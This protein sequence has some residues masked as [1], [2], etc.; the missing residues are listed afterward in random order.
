M[1]YVTLN[2]G[3][4]PP[5]PASGKSAFFVGSD[6]RP[7]MVSDH[8]IQTSLDTLDGLNFLRN[9]GFWFAQRQVPGTLTTYSSTAGRAFTADGWA[10]TNENAS[11]QFRRV[12]TNAAPESGLQSR[13]FGEFTKITANGKIQLSQCIE[14][15]DAIQLRGRNVRLTFWARTVVVASAQ[16]NLALLQLTSAGTIDTIPATFVSAHGAAG[17]D[18]TL[19]TNVSYIPPTSGKTGD[20][21]TA[22]VNSYACTVTTAWQRFSGVFTVPSNCKNLLAMFYSHNQV[23]TTNGV[24]IGQV[25][26]TDGEALQDWEPLSLSLELNRC[27]RF[28][29]KSFLLDTAPAQNVGANSGEVRGV[30]GKAGAVANAGFIPISY[31]VEKRATPTTVTVY[32]PAA[33]NALARNITGAADMGATA[34]TGS[35]AKNFYVNATGVAATAVGD[36]IA[37]HYSADAEL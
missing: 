37:I 17:V 34:I 4:A 7:A 3:A 36:L 14:G 5:T 33:A 8:G 15:S 30:A 22:G 13:Y 18:P 2:Q 25:M 28:Y 35:T 31:T 24:A 32:N 23:V 27:L 11:A 1:S 10:V 16:W 6:R 21:C 26:L 29:E 9:S 19:G 12:D 20:N